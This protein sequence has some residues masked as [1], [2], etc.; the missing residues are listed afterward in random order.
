MRPALRAVAACTLAFGWWHGGVAARLPDWARPIAATAPAIPAGVP[1]YPIRVLFRGIELELLPAGAG[2][3]VRERVAIQV[4]SG[5]SDGASLRSFPFDDTARIKVARGWSLPPGTRSARSGQDAV[6]LSVPD[7]FL[8][9]QKS[10][11][12]IT[13]AAGKGSLIFYE[14]EAE[15][16]PYTLTWRGWL[17]ERAPIDRAV[18]EA[19]LPAGWNVRSAWVHVDGPPAL[20]EGTVHR[21]SLERIEPVDEE[22]VGDDPLSKVPVLALSFQPSHPAVSKRPTFAT[23]DDVAAWYAQLAGGRGDPSDALRTDAL[24]AINAAGTDPTAR[25]F[26]AIR[27]VRDRVRYVAREVGIG[28]YQPHT[29]AETYKDRAGD[30]KDKATL[31]QTVL[32]LDGRTSYPVL[33]NATTPGTVAENVPDP[34]AFNHMVLGVTVSADWKNATGPATVDAGDSGRLLIVD[35]TDEFAPP[36]TLPFYLAGQTGLVVAG[37]RGTLVTLPRARAEDHE[38]ATSLDAHLRPDRS[39]TARLMVLRRG[40]PAEMARQAATRSSKDREA[41]VKRALRSA[42][43]DATPGAYTVVHESPEGAFVESLEF[44]VP[45]PAADGTSEPL[46]FFPDALV[47][48][49]MPSLTRRTGAVTYAYPRTLSFATTVD[50]LAVA[51]AIPAGQRAGGDGWSVESVLSRDERSARGS[52]RLVLERTRYAPEAFPDLKQLWLAASKA[53]SPLIPRD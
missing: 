16:S 49:P 29:V 47:D 28:G 11:F 35:A 15:E 50:G 38:V 4:V 48:L 21:W 46:E 6:D 19:K 33:I 12:I 26:A 7:A 52:W 41:D 43:P 24:A 30:C 37:T 22:P 34:R 51:R 31:L 2:L 23:W 9:D 10:R 3:I 27:F 42:I 36:G 17:Y 13:D 1:K 25:L 8:T 14:F 18:I 40:G 39:M 5:R 45:A 32:A 53:A 44:D 20:R